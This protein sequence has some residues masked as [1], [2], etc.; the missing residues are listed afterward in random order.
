MTRAEWAALECTEVEDF[1]KDLAGTEDYYQACYLWSVVAM[2]LPIRSQLSASKLQRTLFVVQAHDEYVSYLDMEHAV[3]DFSQQTVRKNVARAVMSHP[4]MNETGRLPAFAMFHIDMHIRL[5]LTSERQVAVTDAAGWVR[6][7]EF[8]EREPRRHTEAVEKGNVS[9]VRLLYMPKAL[10][11]ELESVEGASE[12]LP[13]QWLEPRPCPEHAALGVQ[14]KCSKCDS[15]KEYVV[16]PAVTNPRPWSL[17]IQTEDL[18]DIKVKVKRTQLPVVTIK[19]STLHVLQGTTCDPGLI[20]HWALPNRLLPEQ[21]WLAVYVA[22]SRV[23][24]LSKLRSIGLGKNVRKIIQRGPPEE[25]TAQFKKYFG[26]KEKATFESTEKL[27]RK[28]GWNS[29]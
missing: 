15:F 16:V 26:D 18:G 28:L 20:F 13:T 10:Y 14:P 9:M 17:D 25:L 22:L 4:N 27:I 12:S 29:Q 6:G 19:G 2:A 1:A 21:K 23:R 24:K 8:D 11:V 5:T 3:L 7:I